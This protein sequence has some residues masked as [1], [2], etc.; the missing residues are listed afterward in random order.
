MGKGARPD[1]RAPGIRRVKGREAGG[2]LRRPLPA[3]VAALTLLSRVSLALL[4][5]L[6]AGLLLLPRRALLLPLGPGLLAG[7]LLLLALEPLLLALLL[8]SL[9]LLLTLEA[10]LLAPLLSLLL[11][12]AL[13]PLLLA[14]LLKLQCPGLALRKLQLAILLELQSLR[15][16]LSTTLLLLEACLLLPLLAALGA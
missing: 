9:L 16:A 1:G 3:V 2:L 8:L 5:S 6:L 11:L 13:E 4:A 15:L 7:L 12:L 14:A 10:H